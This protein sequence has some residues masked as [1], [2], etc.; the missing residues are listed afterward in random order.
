MIFGVPAAF[1]IIRFRPP[2]PLADDEPSDIIG[3]Y[4][5]LAERA[6]DDETFDPR[7]DDMAPTHFEPDLDGFEPGDHLIK[8]RQPDF[9]T[10]DEVDWAD[11]S[12]EQYVHMRFD[13]PDPND[14]EPEGEDKTLG[15]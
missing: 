10:W 11:P 4:Q 13:D 15:P 14:K 1:F 9:N 12:D 5:E 3:V 2:R 6:R 7:E 8:S